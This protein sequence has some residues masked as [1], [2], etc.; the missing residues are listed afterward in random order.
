MIQ[1]YILFSYQ[2]GQDENQGVA[3][4]SV[5]TGA[6]CCSVT[7]L[8]II[9]KVV[10]RLVTQVELP[11]DFIPYYITRCTKT[12]EDLE[13]NILLFIHIVPMTTTICPEIGSG[14]L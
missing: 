3:V 8:E 7:S 5:P 14:E 4:L 13:V 10:N 11:S 2:P 1:V 6:S 9:E 12:C